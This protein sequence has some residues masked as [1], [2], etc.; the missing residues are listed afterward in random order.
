[1]SDSTADHAEALALIDRFRA[2]GD[3]SDWQAEFPADDARQRAL[4]EA[5]DRIGVE[6]FNAGDASW[7]GVSFITRALADVQQRLAEM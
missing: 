4:A 2:A 1:M 3:P 7:P 6:A 5:F